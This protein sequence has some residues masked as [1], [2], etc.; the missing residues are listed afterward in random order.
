MYVA[1]DETLRQMAAGSWV[2]YE[3]EIEAL[4]HAHQRQ[5]LLFWLSPADAIRIRE[6]VNL[7]PVSRSILSHIQ[8]RSA[9]YQQG[10]L[11]SE[12]II[13]LCSPESVQ[14]SF[15]IVGSTVRYTISGFAERF[16]SHRSSL[17]VEN[18]LSDGRAIEAIYR[19]YC[20]YKRLPHSMAKFWL[21]HG[22]GSGLCSLFEAIEPEE[23]MGLCVCDSDVMPF[24]SQLCRPGG[25]ADSAVTTCTKLNAMQRADFG[26]SQVHP[27]FAFDLTGART[28]EGLV[29]PQLLECYF[30]ANQ[31]A[32]AERSAF[33]QLMPNFPRLTPEQYVLWIST[34]LKDGTASPVELE[35]AL[36]AAL[37]NA[38]LP[39]RA[40]LEGFAA[41]SF[42]GNVI[43]WIWLNAQAGRH[44]RDNVRAMGFDLQNDH[45][46]C[47]VERLVAR[48]WTMLA[49][50]A[51]FRV[52]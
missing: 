32:R 31:Q 23:I 14:G 34:N 52:A 7:G 27:V 30:G 16:A 29:G 1:L 6:E 28:I 20:N 17:F 13:V 2:E 11:K 18:V 35:A 21:R 10:L 8:R 40:W 4:L 46:R 22:G 24:G 15:Q 38:V 45:Y 33:A 50:D 9:D 37:P 42:P 48:S 12:R 19:L 41:L 49:A 51:A 26:Y 5:A 43:Q 39:S 47:H 3:L 36:N 44:V 25:T